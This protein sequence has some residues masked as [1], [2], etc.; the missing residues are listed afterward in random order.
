MLAFVRAIWVGLLRI[1]EFYA[2]WRVASW[3]MGDAV[4]NVLSESA[5]DEKRTVWW[6]RLWKAHPPWEARRRT[7]DDPRRLFDISLDLPIL[8]G[9]LL[10]L[11]LIGTILLLMVFYFTIAQLNEILFWSLVNQ[12]I[13]WLSPSNRPVFGLF[14]FFFRLMPQT[15]LTA[16]IPIFVAYL[17]AE[18][19]G[20]Q[21]QRETL[22]DLVD[23][24]H[25]SSGYL[26]LGKPALLL[27][28]GLELG[29]LIAPMSVLRPQTPLAI[30]LTPIWFAVF[31]FLVWLWLAHNRFIARYMLG[32]HAE[33]SYPKFKRF[34]VVSSSVLFFWVLLLPALVGRA[35]IQMTGAAALAPFFPEGLWDDI[36]TYGFLGT[37]VVLL[38]LA[39]WFYL[40]GSLFLLIAF[41]SW[42]HI[43]PRR[44]PACHQVT[45]HK[46][47]VGQ[48]CKHCN[49]ELAPWIYRDATQ[50]STII[51]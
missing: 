18:T 10:A 34:L 2:D 49:H 24:D 32:T 37:T 23:N 5:A 7:L 47:V 8:T 40:G 30:L 51:N 43:F 48:T 1:R 4:K 46:I 45:P 39:F 38:I 19:V 27:A 33:K 22:A 13:E 41:R 42:L 9:L 20:L 11:V 15:L 3:G 26:R 29:W 21:V 16:S 31:T 14:F 17:V 44:C 25:S 35:T 36:F 12:E 6:E 50:K 28:F